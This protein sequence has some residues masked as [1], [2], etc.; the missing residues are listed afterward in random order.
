MSINPNPVLTFGSDFVDSGSSA[1]DRITNDVNFSLVV[2]GLGAGDSVAYQYSTD[3]GN[4]WI[5]T[6]ASQ[7]NLADGSYQVRALITYESGY[8]FEGEL[9]PGNWIASID[10][11]GS[12]DISQSPLSI[13]LLGA[14]DIGESSNPPEAGYRTD[15]VISS[16]VAWTASFD[17]NYSTD[18]FMSSWDPFGYLINGNFYQLTIDSSDLLQS[19]SVTISLNAGD[20]F[21]FR[22]GSVDAAYGRA[23]VQISGFVAD[24]SSVYSNVQS[25]AIDSTAAAAPSLA[26]TSD[27]GVS[28]TD[29]ITNDG[30]INVTGL[31]A[32]ASWQYSINSGTNWISGTGSS[33]A[34]A[35]G[36]YAAG[37]I[38][39]RQSDI[40]GNTSAIG[41]LGGITIIDSTAVTPSLA[42]ANDTGVSATDG[43]TNDGTINVTGLEAGA[44][45]Q[46]S[47]NSGSDW[48]SATGSSFAIASDTYDAG[49]ILVRQSDIAG[50]TSA[51]GQLGAITIIDST[52]AAAPSLALA[53]DTGVSAT[54]GITN[55]GTINVA[56][57]EADA[58]WQYSINS[59][60]NWINGTGSSFALASGSYAAGTIF[61]RQSD[62]A[63]NTS[64][65][66]QL[67]AITIIDSTAA[68][69]PSLALASDTGISATDGIT[70][71]STINV[72]G[73]EADASWQYSTNGGG[74]WTNGIG[75]SFE[76]A[77]GT[78]AAG[79]ILVRQSDIAGN[80][81]A[82]G[83]LGATITVDTTAVA[84][85]LVLASDSGV[86]ATDRNTNNGTINVAGLEAG[87]SWQYSTNSGISWISGTG[88]SFVLASGTYTAGR[89]RVRQS[90]I[91]G[92]TSAIGQTTSTVVIDTT[93]PTTTAAITAV[94]DNF[95]IFQGF[96]DNSGVT[97][98]TTPTFSGIIS[99]ALVSG[100]ALY[101]FNGD[102]RLGQAVVNNTAKTWSCTLSTPLPNTEG[103]NYTITA[104]VGD[105]AGNLG[106]AS[107]SRS[108]L[109]DTSA[110]AIT[111]SITGVE[112]NFGP[113]TGF[114]PQA[115]FTDDTSPT[116][117]GTLS[118]PLSA[119]DTLR[120]YSGTTWLGNASMANDQQTWSFTSQPLANGFY[121]ITAQVADAAGNLAPANAVQRLSIDSTSNQI[122]GDANANTLTATTAKDVLT[123]LDGI[124]TFRFS[125][126]GSS[127]LT[128]F[129]RITDFAIGT[130]ILDGPTAVSAANI[131]KLG[132]V[133]ALNTA[134]IA[135]VL[136]TSAFAAS[137]AATFTFNDPS[138]LSRSFVALNNASAGYQSGSDA[139]IEITGYTGSLNN[140]QIV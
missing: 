103:A 120:I 15:I 7:S 60:N 51:I 67:G 59:G 113:L 73:L 20:V 37:S 91:A 109:L 98:D 68:A 76:I 56:D 134:S 21:G 42:L 47:T 77:S 10:G 105:L 90:D 75:S 29:G 116:F 106:S 24:Y 127:L 107:S 89:I 139:I 40:A 41:Q 129:D 70:N 117:S 2:A 11:N 82:N 81:S 55:D 17:W 124:D 33:F 136:T 99:A 38:L 111:A 78:Y 63:G 30:T 54:D 39:V 126:L 112:D 53:N 18:D 87:A 88:S 110:P 96:V 27:T 125:T 69:A 14:D 12:I 8:G 3:A 108:F 79:S 23:S 83:Q 61:V 121:A 5:T 45:W 115:G 94:A 34:L 93:A 43:I 62:I 49:S 132:A 22:Q 66:G 95:G 58:S 137:R 131:N 84:S 104:R 140:L 133:S 36:S 138:G 118:S 92:N 119:G 52:A 48:I 97:D 65:I 122:I 80:T 44:S 19:G 31:E 57:L 16:P 114:L 123:G 86:S 74:N 32:G 130:D 128:R 1:V 46:Y 26:L 13:A 4:S 25:F 100:E 102:T 71:D 6:A 64:A 72:T 101:L 35:T 135:A 85:S 9:S 28:A 50:N